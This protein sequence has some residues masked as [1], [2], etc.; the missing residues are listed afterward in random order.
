MRF[1][2]RMFRAIDRITVRH[3]PSLCRLAAV[4][5]SHHLALRS[6][7]PDNTGNAPGGSL[8]ASSHLARAIRIRPG[9][10]SSR[11]HAAKFP[12]SQ[13]LSQPI[14]GLNPN[15]GRRFR[16]LSAK[17]LSRLPATAL[18]HHRDVLLIATLLPTVSIKSPQSVLLGQPP[19]ARQGPK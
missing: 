3:T 19:S 9:C 13:R 18:I 17:L 2:P 15:C 16:F 10:P 11:R 7:S 5:S 1:W 12:C 4:P 14:T 6:C 8:A